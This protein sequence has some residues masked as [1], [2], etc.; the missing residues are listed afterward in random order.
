VAARACMPVSTCVH[1]C[2]HVV[3][4]GCKVR[5]RKQDENDYGLD[6]MYDALIM[7]PYPLANSYKKCAPYSGMT[8]VVSDD[9]GYCLLSLYYFGVLLDREGPLPLARKA[10]RQCLLGCGAGGPTD[11]W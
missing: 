2:E 7:P 11:T 5:E 3:A 1:A 4:V 6:C 10:P 9:G 8:M